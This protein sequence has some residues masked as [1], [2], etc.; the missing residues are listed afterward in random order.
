M[1]IS[2]EVNVQKYAI[3]IGENI[4]ILCGETL[5]PSVDEY[6][7]PDDIDYETAPIQ[8]Q[9]PVYMWVHEGRFEKQRSRLNIQPNGTLI[10]TKV[11]RNDSGT[12]TC[13]VSGP[14]GEYVKQKVH[15]FVRSKLIINFPSS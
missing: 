2:A 3:D 12:Y 15:I 1:I 13:T 7:T 5:V 8:Y 9:P 4:S 11:N 14:D 6:H 10:L